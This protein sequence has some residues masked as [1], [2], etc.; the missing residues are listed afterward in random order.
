MGENYE[1]GISQGAAGRWGW[2]RWRYA[3]E[4]AKVVPGGKKTIAAIY[5]LA[6]VLGWWFRPAVEMLLSAGPEWITACGGV[7][8]VHAAL[9]WVLA[10][11]IFALLMLVFW[12]AGKFRT[13]RQQRL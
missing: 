9:P 6:K 12:L 7:G 4:R 2:L 11:V 13:A 8:L 3:S 10:I 5:V 1:E